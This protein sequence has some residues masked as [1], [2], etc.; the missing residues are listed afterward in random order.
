MYA[1]AAREISARRAHPSPRS[2]HI[3]APSTSACVR[4]PNRDRGR[5]LRQARPLYARLP[6]GLAASTCTAARCLVGPCRA[7]SHVGTGSSCAGSCGNCRLEQCR[8]ASGHF[9]SG[10][11]TI[12]VRVGQGP[13]TGGLMGHPPFVRCENLQVKTRTRRLGR[14][15][16]LSTQAED[17]RWMPGHREPRLS[18]VG[19]VYQFFL[20]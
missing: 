6:C 19:W 4:T 11:L 8:S 7:G 5:T 13:H 18:A 14:E 17:A 15:S 2:L 12:P 20:P 16:A 3:Q 9:F 10:Y 1:S